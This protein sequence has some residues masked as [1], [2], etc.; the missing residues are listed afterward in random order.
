MCRSAIYLSDFGVEVRL[1][2]H[3]MVDCVPTLSVLQK[4]LCKLGVVFVKSLE[5]THG[6]SPLPPSTPLPSGWK[7]SGGWR[8]RA[9]L[10]SVRGRTF[11]QAARAPSG[12]WAE[13]V[14][15]AVPSTA[16]RVRHGCW[17]GFSSQ[18]SQMEE[19]QPR[20]KIWCP[21]PPPPPP[22]VAATADPA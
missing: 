20:V 19:V 17:V 6:D 10:S 16:G 22:Q 5:L 7:L 14:N 13:S 9:G 3:N 21:S 2:S 15:P 18:A 11:Q 4:R 12:K 1:A 8:R